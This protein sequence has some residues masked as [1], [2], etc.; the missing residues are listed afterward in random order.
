MCSV[1]TG[2]LTPA[3]SFLHWLEG[4]LCRVKG[5]GGGILQIRGLQEDDSGAQPHILGMSITSVFFPNLLIVSGWWTSLGRLRQISSSWWDYFKE[6]LKL[7]PG[8]IN[9]MT[10]SPP[11]P[12]PKKIA[13]GLKR[14]PPFVLVVRVFQKQKNGDK[15]PEKNTV[16]HP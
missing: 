6:L 10:L 7:Q 13:V 15:S 16:P 5:Y 11:C 8:G 4:L 12:H 3:Y 14:K 1:I 2:Y 9:V